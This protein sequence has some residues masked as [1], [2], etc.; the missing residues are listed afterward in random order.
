MPSH[1]TLLDAAGLVVEAWAVDGDGSRVD[2]P[3]AADL[4]GAR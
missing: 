1:V 2:Q 4:S 3:R